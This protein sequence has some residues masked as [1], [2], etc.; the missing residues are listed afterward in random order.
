MSP[1]EV[2]RLLQAALVREARSVGQLDALIAWAQENPS[3]PLWRRQVI[4]WLQEVRQFG[5]VPD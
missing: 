1:R 5:A 4:E 3:L 2:T